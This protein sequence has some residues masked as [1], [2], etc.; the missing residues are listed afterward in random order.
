MADDVQDIYV[1]TGSGTE[2]QSLS[3]LAAEQVDASLPIQ[4]DD[5]TVVLD[6]PSA[7]TFTVSTNGAER[8]RVNNSGLTVISANGANNTSLTSGNSVSVVDC[9]LSNTVANSAFG[10]RVDGTYRFYMTS[11]GNVGIGD[12]LTGPSQ[13][14]AVD[15]SVGATSY[16][17]YGSS[18][19]G[20][21][22]PETTTIEIHPG[23]NQVS[24]I[25]S[26]TQTTVKGPAD[27]D[28]QIDLDGSA[29]ISGSVVG[30]NVGDP[31]KNITFGSNTSGIAGGDGVYVLSRTHSL[32]FS[33]N[34]IRFNSDWSGGAAEPTWVMTT[35]HGLVAQNA[36][37]YIKCGT[38]KGLA[39]TDAQIDLGAELLTTNHTPTQPNSIATKKY[40]DDNAG[41]PAYDDTQIKADLANEASVRAAAD[42]TLQANIDAKIWVGTTSQYMAIDPRDRLP[43][44]LYCLTD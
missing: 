13:K 40:V 27:T 23:S 9:D 29:I 18:S 24:F 4:S 20:M 35:D 26:S 44:T 41:S 17:Q 8:V 12:S 42:T 22:F 16:V 10:I 6:S 30:F 39:D 19:C 38:V 31:S 32:A 34:E 1:S 36:N 25:S 21:F 33:S 43:T 2:W 5:G 11:N 15:G 14:L 28:A 7:D 3:A 37:N